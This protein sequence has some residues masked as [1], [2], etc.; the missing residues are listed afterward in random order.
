MTEL[1]KGLVYKISNDKDDY[2][3]VGSTTQKI[4]QRWATHR[5]YA[6]NN[7]KGLLYD[8]IREIGINNFKIIVMLELEYENKY[9][10]RKAEDDLI[11]S[12]KNTLNANSACLSVE[13]AKSSYEARNKLVSNR[14]SKIFKNVNTDYKNDSKRCVICNLSFVNGCSKQHYKT[15]KHEK[16]SVLYYKFK[17]N[18]TINQ[19]IENN[20]I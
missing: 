6:R 5:S 3:Y 13:K 11:K 1:K 15:K 19:L 4:S 10:L 2:V 14:N 17:F 7:K 16:Q 12:F 8:K 9:E 20:R 18:D